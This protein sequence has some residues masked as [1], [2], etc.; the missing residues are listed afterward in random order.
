LFVKNKNNIEEISQF[1]TIKKNNTLL[2]NQVDEEIG[3]FYELAIKEISKDI[4]IK[5]SFNKDKIN[6]DET[7]ELF[8]EEKIYLYHLTSS[9]QIEEIAKKH[10]RKIIVSDYKNFKR[11]QKNFQT[12]N[13]YDYEKD[14][15]YFFKNI[16]KI[17]EQE[18]INY[19][20]SHPYF[21]MSEAT[22]YKVNKSSYLADSN[23][24][25]ANNSI[26]D[27][28]KSI[29]SLKRSQTDIKKLFMMLKNEVKYKKFNFLVS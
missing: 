27:I 2:I 18:L 15:A 8:Q 10:Y 26:L 17:N 21:T 14:I 6:P 13:G 19:C 9:K 22:K 16:Y 3:S 29:F 25:G 4:D 20:I 12:V 11:F 1:L 23:I 24:N 5:I 28:R 7:S